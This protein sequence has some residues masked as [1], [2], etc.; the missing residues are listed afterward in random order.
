MLR[1]GLAGWRLEGFPEIQV[2]N[3]PPGNYGDSLRYLLHQSPKEFIRLVNKEIPLLDGVHA[4]SIT[5]ETENKETLS[6]TPTGW[7]AAE[8]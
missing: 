5:T 7:P 3:S 1:K 8:T 2:V 4:A 6:P